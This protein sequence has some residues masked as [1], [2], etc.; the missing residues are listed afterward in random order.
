MTAEEKAIAD[1]LKSGLSAVEAE[2][3]DMSGGCGTM[4]NI[5]VVSDKFHGLSTVQQHKAVT[6]VLKDEIS[7]WH[8]FTLQCKV[9]SR[10]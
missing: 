10:E 7:S 9:P 3:K 2:V 4:F 8:G 1:K 6:S 5:S